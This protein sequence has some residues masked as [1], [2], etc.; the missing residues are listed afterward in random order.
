[1]SPIYHDTRTDDGFRRDVEDTSGEFWLVEVD[2]DPRL[3]PV[4]GSDRTFLA[5]APAYDS[6]V[7]SPTVSSLHDLSPARLRA[8]DETA[9]T[10]RLCQSGTLYVDSDE[11]LFV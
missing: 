1:M 9:V 5:L 10:Y 4:P 2:A 7:Q 11:A 3:M 8:I 6:D